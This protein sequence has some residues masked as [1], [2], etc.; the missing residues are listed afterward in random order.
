[1]LRSAARSS[2][3]LPPSGHF[4]SRLLPAR[5]DTN[6]SHKLFASGPRR[7]SQPNTRVDGL[8]SRPSCRDSGPFRF[9]T[10]SSF[11]LEAEETSMHTALD[12]RDADPG[13]GA[14]ALQVP[15]Y[16]LPTAT[17]RDVLLNNHFFSC[18]QNP[19]KFTLQG[20]N[21]YLIHVSL[22]LP[23][24][25][26]PIR[27]TFPTHSSLLPCPLAAHAPS[28]AAPLVAPPPPP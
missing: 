19:G 12:L 23:L 15:L 9:P 27:L 25:C 10:F 22:H 3:H 18:A 16:A 14:F 5:Q 28:P 7:H 17:A 4:G 21:S 11:P 24:F 2:P 1:M 6:T 13:P 20:T 8:S 26:P